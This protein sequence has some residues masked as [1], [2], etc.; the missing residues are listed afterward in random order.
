MA[1][2]ISA[3]RKNDGAEVKV[4]EE[5]KTRWP[6]DFLWEKP[7]TEAAAAPAPAGDQPIPAQPEANVPQSPA[8][9]TETPAEPGAEERTSA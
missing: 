6:D 1:K 8:G 5:W 3:W 4:S 2:L 9:D 7:A